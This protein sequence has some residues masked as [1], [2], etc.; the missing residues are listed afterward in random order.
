MKKM[1]LKK[2]SNL[3]L[4]SVLPQ[5]LL[6]MKLMSSRTECETDIKDIIFLM[7]NLKIDTEEKANRIIEAVF[8]VEYILPK[9]RY[10]IEECLENIRHEKE[11]NTP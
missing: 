1:F 6:A 11:T 2:Y 10:V 9:T 7:K 8:K 3:K 5:Y 4:H